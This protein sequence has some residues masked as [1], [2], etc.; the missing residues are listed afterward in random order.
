MSQATVRVLLR[1][2]VVVGGIAMLNFEYVLSAGIVAVPFADARAF[3][4]RL[5]AAG[6][7]VIDLVPQAPDAPAL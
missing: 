6:V 4:D 2:G 7:D 3:A 5:L 1:E